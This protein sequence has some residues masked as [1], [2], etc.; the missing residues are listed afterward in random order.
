MS[1]FI[2]VKILKLSLYAG[3]STGQLDKLY[4]SIPGLFD[5]YNHFPTCYYILY[6]LQGSS[7]LRLLIKER[8]KVRKVT[9]QPESRH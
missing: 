5:N 3:P 2:K 1:P 8:S 6:K 7:K 4:L 9:N